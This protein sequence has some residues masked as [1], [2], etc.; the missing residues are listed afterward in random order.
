M[1]ELELTLTREFDAE[2]VRSKLGEYLR[3]SE[4]KILFLR[5]AEPPAILQLLGDALAWLP[6]KAAGAVY[7]S[8]L[9]KRSGDATWNLWASR[10][11]SNEVR[12][13]A[14]VAK[15][16]AKAADSVNGK[17]TILVGVN[18]PDDTYGTVISIEPD[19]P[20]EMA[21]VLARIMQEP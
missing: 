8:T 17:I 21:R 13:L 9:A 1:S 5:S 14:N 7:L 10:F 4:P 6:L 11:N 12:P 2:A 18:I 16:L 3:V 19:D 15:T 20:E